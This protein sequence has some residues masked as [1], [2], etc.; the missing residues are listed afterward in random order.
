MPV[1]LKDDQAFSTR[2]YLFKC[3]KPNSVKT[4]FNLGFLLC[5]NRKVNSVAIN[6][7]TVGT[8]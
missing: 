5:G 1:V 8:S 2:R 6:V 4:M 3:K 7:G